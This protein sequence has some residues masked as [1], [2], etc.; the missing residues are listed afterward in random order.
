MINAKTAP[1]YGLC[2]IG[3]LGL[4]G[5][6]NEVPTKTAMP[7]AV[8]VSFVDGVAKLEDA[9]DEIKSAFEAGTPHECDGALH[10]AADIVK[11][12][13]E[14]AISEGRFNGEQMKTVD[15]ASGE[16]FKQFALLHEGFHPKPG[17]DHGAHDGHD[18]DGHEGHD[19]DG[20]GEHAEHEVDGHA[21]HDDHDHGH[22]H[23][24]TDVAE[25]IDTA[26]QQLKSLPN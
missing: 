22:G 2:F 26:L 23:A 10:T 8:A 15:T 18:H 9:K 5:C 4:L 16:L 14:L 21:D 6:T 24:Y 25:A 12:L 17:H 20:H 7:A 13:P 19:H 3:L 1:F 11:A